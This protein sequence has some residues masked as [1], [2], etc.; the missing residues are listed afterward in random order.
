MK[1]FKVAICLMLIIATAIGACGCMETNHK[2]TLAEEIRTDALAYLNNNYSDT[3]TA[4][5]FTSSNWAYEYESITFTSQ[6][7]PDAIVEVRVYRN[8]DGTYRFK[9]NYYHCYMMDSTVCYGKSLFAEENAV[10][11]VRFANTVWSDKL[12][13]ARSFEEWVAQGSARA[14][15]FV[16]TGNALSAD[17]QTEIVEK[18]ANDKVCGY[19]TFFV[20]AEENL[21]QDMS[22]DEI[23]NQQSKF[24]AGENKYFIN[25]QFEI[26]TN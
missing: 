4:K 5:L 18:I 8:D 11:K 16:I 22:L 19:V 24:V 20:T 15:F 14:D 23:L 6:K 3:F 10:V 26:K 21:L 13:G 1:N 25:R 12:N 7:Y 17:E 2:D 9:D